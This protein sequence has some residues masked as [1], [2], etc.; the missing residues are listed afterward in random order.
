MSF[1]NLKPLIKDIPAFTSQI[2]SSQKNSYALLI[3]VIN[4]G[5]RI[6]AQLLKLRDYSNQVDIFIVDGGS[7]DNSLDREYLIQNN[8]TGLFTKT[9][10]GALS[11]QLRIGLMEILRLGYQGV[12]LMDGNNKDNPQAIPKFMQK[13][14]E[15][16]D[17]VQGSRFIKG[18]LSRNTP[19]L[20]LLAIRFIHAPL[21]S[22]AAGYRYT[23]T[24]NGFRA[25]S[26]KFLLDSR[27]QPFRAIFNR[28]ELHYYLAIKAA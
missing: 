22:M 27:V 12:I 9:G 1:E 6:R 17:H 19:L 15:G 26:R 16:Y 13:L 10:P 14:A 11:A 23:D 5:E 7:T 25:Y 4:E 2:F 3:P 24:T 18:G 21:M 28:Y 20:R 8:M